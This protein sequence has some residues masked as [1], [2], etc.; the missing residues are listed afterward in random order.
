MPQRDVSSGEQVVWPIADGCVH[1]EVTR[2][3][4]PAR[5]GTRPNGPVIWSELTKGSARR[6]E[7]L[8]R[9]ATNC[10]LCMWLGGGVRVS[11][12][13]A[14][15]CLPAALEN[16]SWRL[17]ELTPQP[18]PSHQGSPGLSCVM[19]KVMG[20]SDIMPFSGEPRGHVPQAIRGHTAGRVIRIG[21][22]LC[23]PLPTSPPSCQL[24]PMSAAPGQGSAI[25]L[26]PLW[27]PV[28]GL[29]LWGPISQQTATDSGQETAGAQVSTCSSTQWFLVLLGWG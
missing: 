29:L 10:P 25:R 20:A 6:E 27:P 26:S 8:G 5:L 9:S 14:I 24:C 11:E 28:V 7:P 16:A 17:L 21:G 3:C 1:S 15:P 18:P 19:A 4:T 23:G 2:G 22:C 12:P 13:A